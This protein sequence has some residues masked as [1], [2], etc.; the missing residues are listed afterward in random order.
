MGGAFIQVVASTKEEVVVELELLKAK[1][2]SMGLTDVRAQ[3][4]E[5]DWPYQNEE[6]QTIISPWGGIIHVHS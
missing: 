5:K 1:A 3:Q 2:A 6:G 4:V